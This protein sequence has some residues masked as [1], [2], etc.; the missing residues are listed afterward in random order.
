[1]ES[2]KYKLIVVEGVLFTF[3]AYRKV[4]SKNFSPTN[5][6]RSDGPEVFYHLSVSLWELNPD[7]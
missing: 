6:D 3:A 7:F 4:L 1:M 5:T 2:S